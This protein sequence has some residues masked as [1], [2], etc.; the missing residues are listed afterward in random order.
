MTIHGDLV[1]TPYELYSGR[2][3]DLS[4]FCTFGCCVYVECPRFRRSTQSEIDSRTGILLG[5]A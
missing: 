5:Y 1:K 4:R 2:K 3:A